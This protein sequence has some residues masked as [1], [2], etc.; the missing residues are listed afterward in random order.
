MIRAL[1]KEA[2]A[3]RERKAALI[4]ASGEYESAQ[5]L[6]DAASLLTHTPVGLELRQLQTLERI[7]KEPN[8][9]TYVIPDSVLNDPDSLIATGMAGTFGNNDSHMPVF[10]N[11]NDDNDINDIDNSNDGNSNNNS[12]IMLSQLMDMLQGNSD[13]NEPVFR[14]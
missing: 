7:S 14:S 13:G 3:T 11:D 6:K 10:D 4:R 8:Q 9:Q 2:E 1:A 12:N 5:K